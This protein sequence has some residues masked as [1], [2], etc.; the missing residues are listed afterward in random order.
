[1]WTEPTI[2]GFGRQAILEI[3][4][5]GFL[6]RPVVLVAVTRLKGGRIALRRGENIQVE[7]LPENTLGGLV[8]LDRR[9][10]AVAVGVVVH[11]LLP[12]LAGA[13]LSTLT[14]PLIGALPADE[15]ARS[16]LGL[17][18][19]PSCGLLGLA[20]HLAC[21]VRGLVRGV[22]HLL[23]GPTGRILHVL[24]YLAHLVRDPAERPPT[25]LLAVA[26]L[27]AR[28]AAG[29]APH[30]VLGLL[31]GPTCGLLACL[32]RGLPRH[33]LGLVRSL[34]GRILCLLLAVL[35]LV[36]YF[37]HWFLLLEI[38]VP[39]PYD[40]T[41]RVPIL[42]ATQP[43]PVRICAVNA[44]HDLREFS[45]AGSSVFEASGSENDLPL[46]PGRNFVHLVGVHLARNIAHGLR[47]LH[48][49]HRRRGPHRRR[50]FHRSHRVFPQA[51]QR[52]RVHA[53][54]LY[55]LH[56]FV[57]PHVGRILPRQDTP[58]HPPVGR[59]H[60]FR[61]P[62]LRFPLATF[63]IPYAHARPPYLQAVY[64]PRF[65]RVEVVVKYLLEGVAEIVLHLAHQ[66]SLLIQIFVH[67]GQVGDAAD[68]VFVEDLTALVVGGLQ[69]QAA[70][71]H[72][73][74]DAVGGVAG[75]FPGRVALFDPL[76]QLALAIT[77]PKVLHGDP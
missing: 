4:R 77:A 49:R 30:G 73:A 48:R 40:A 44:R 23:G 41:K 58:A 67:H 15:P 27:A 64:Q 57:G 12:R 74:H 61:Y 5:V 9:R 26:L 10:V 3:S 47:G 46:G 34:S 19:S 35:L 8:V 32:V 11:F 71:V 66:P 54:L 37:A 62:V 63:L 22:L 17:L 20:R 76:G 52:K 59:A 75:G 13:L 55:P 51:R 43:S 39:C 24:G 14:S 53:A 6:F 28:E 72:A 25:L 2:D 60:P 56:N 1:M 42:I 31:H 21:L 69:D 68:H 65:Q 29:Q 70:L 33:L 36:L 7:E 38:V 18:H 50:R 16:A 45:L